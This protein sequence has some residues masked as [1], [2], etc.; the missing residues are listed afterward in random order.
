MNYIDWILLI[1]LFA[2][3]FQGYRKGLLSVFRGFL[4]YAVGLI[5]AV[6]YTGSLTEIMNRNWAITTSLAVWLESVLPFPVESGYSGNS[7]SAETG[8]LVNNL[9]LPLFVKEHLF[10]RIQEEAA[11]GGNL[12][13]NAGQA[14]AEQIAFLLVQALAFIILFFITVV[15]IRFLIGLITRGLRYTPLR[16]INR[17]TGLFAGAGIKALLITLVLGLLSPLLALGSSEAAGGFLG[18][19]GKGLDNSLLVPYFLGWFSMLSSWLYSYF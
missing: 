6:A 5:V 10:N 11:A 2:G 13:S 14:V 15:V 12:M 4:S 17:L 19:L 1:I 8:S 18:W 16:G 9:P 3:A 7:G